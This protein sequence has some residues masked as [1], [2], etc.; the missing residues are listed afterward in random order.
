MNVWEWRNNFMYKQ[1]SSLLVYNYK[2]K[3]TTSPLVASLQQR[4]IGLTCFTFA[5]RS[6]GTNKWLA[7]MAKQQ[8]RLDIPIPYPPAQ[9][10][11]SSNSIPKCSR[12]RKLV[13]PPEI[14]ERSV[15]RHQQNGMAIILHLSL[16]DLFI[17][18]SWGGIAAFILLERSQKVF[19]RPL[20][21]LY[22]C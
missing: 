18:M 3:E 12:L 8:V 15:N 4:S 1:S 19:L 16:G 20:K 17:R 7:L 13:R 9:D 5:L 10:K 11:I 14:W 2:P 22:A 6:V 21:C